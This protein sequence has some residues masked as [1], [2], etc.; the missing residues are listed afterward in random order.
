MV[1]KTNM[2]PMYDEI[3]LELLKR[4]KKKSFQA[5]AKIYGEINKG[6]NNAILKKSQNLTL[7]L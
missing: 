5:T 1:S 6:I 4:M 2:T 3:K 7:V